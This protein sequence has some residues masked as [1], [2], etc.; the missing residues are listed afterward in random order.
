[1][2][3]QTKVSIVKLEYTTVA[4]QTVG[5]LEVN[6]PLHEDV[7]K[8]IGDVPTVNLLFGNVPVNCILDTE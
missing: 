7:H 3:K 5:C 2:H 1:M 6:G 8:L 4:A